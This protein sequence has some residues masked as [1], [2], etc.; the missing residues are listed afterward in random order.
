MPTALVLL[1]LS[2]AFYSAII[3]PCR[4]NYVV[5]VFPPEHNS[6]TVV[7]LVYVNL[8]GL[9]SY[10]CFV[11]A[12]TTFHQPLN[13][14]GPPRGGA[15][16]AICPGPQACGGPQKHNR[17]KNYIN[18]NPKASIFKFDTPGTTLVSWQFYLLESSALCTRIVAIS[19]NVVKVKNGV[20]TVIFRGGS[21]G[22]QV[23]HATNVKIARVN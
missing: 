8:C 1:D 14:A 7:L 3:Q 11:S 5:F 20:Q 23:S 13:H 10:L 21:R 17:N 12:Q 6:L 19:V 9:Q 2:K 22:S 18:I 15:K 4:I 16:G